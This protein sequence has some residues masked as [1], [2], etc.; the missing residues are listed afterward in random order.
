V[1]RIVAVAALTVAAACA[2]VGPPPG[3][4]ED[5]TPPQLA[6]TIPAADS[7]GVAPAQPVSIAFSESID[8]RSVMRS[9]RVIP[10]VEFGEASWSGDTLRLA[11]EGRWP[12]DRPVQVWIGDAAED[13]RG[14]RLEAPIL[15]RFTTGDS[16]PPG[17]IA[18]RIWTGRE[19]TATNRLLVAAFPAAALDS[20]SA[21]E[22]DPSALAIP[23][24]DGTFRLGGLAPG[25][26]RV[27][28]FLD[29]DADA[30][31]GG[32]SEVV[33]AAPTTI[34]LTGETPRAVLPDFLVGTLDSTGTIAGDARAD[35]GAV[36][37]EAT[38]DST[39]AADARAIL[40]SGGPFELKV[41]TGR[42]YRLVGFADADQDS[43]WDEG[44]TRLV[45]PE[46]VSL[47]LTAERKGFL[48]DLRTGA[49]KPAAPPE[50]P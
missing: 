19:K 34:A 6:S 9:L 47:E 35:S 26:Y 48:I 15:F 30:R 24:P 25:D 4:P 3:G 41:P 23:G 17:E 12:E 44:E 28:G 29:G 21:S 5:R 37:V 32:T 18:G 1:R 33:T 20:A 36:I 46:P 10:E 38:S 22:D 40:P 13:S 16:L 27:V 39:R 50:T 14:N 2:K 45:H 43:T 42:A 7:A 31:A 8:K 49:P 11:P